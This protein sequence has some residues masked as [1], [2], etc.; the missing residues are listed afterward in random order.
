MIRSQSNY[1]R[2]LLLHR[3]TR[4]FKVNKGKLARVVQYGRMVHHKEQ[5]LACVPLEAPFPHEMLTWDSDLIRWTFHSNI[6]IWHFSWGFME[7]S[8]PGW[9]LLNARARQWKTRGKKSACF[10]T[11]KLDSVQSPTVESQGVDLRLNINSDRSRELNRIVMK[12]KM[13]SPEWVVQPSS[14]KQLGRE[15]SALGSCLSGHATD[16]WLGC[17]WVLVFPFLGL[18]SFP[19]PVTT[20]ITKGRG[21][22]TRAPPYTHLL[23]GLFQRTYRKESRL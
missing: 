12:T 9:L 13:V 22:V 7:W 17:D 3:Q 14:I 20:Q 15:R 10:N 4:L 19:T 5:D 16:S 18:I 6:L 1:Q 23:P 21:A 2:C 11:M 8:N